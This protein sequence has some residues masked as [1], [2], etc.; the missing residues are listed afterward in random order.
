MSTYKLIIKRILSFNNNIFQPNYI[1]DNIN[2]FCKLYF[3]SLLKNEINV[4]TKYK[5]F[6]NTINN[7]ISSKNDVVKNEFIELFCN[8]QKTYNS[9]NR[10]SCIIKYNRAKLIVDED[11][12]LNKLEQNTKNVICI[13]QN[14][15]KYLFKVHDLIQIIETSLTNSHFF[16]AE[17][18]YIKNPYTNLPFNKSTLYNIYFFIK[19]ETTCFC[20]LFFKFYNCNFNM[21]LFKMNNEYLLREHSIKNY[22]YKSTNVRLIEEIKRLI[23]FYNDNNRNNKILIDTDFPI[24]KLIKIFQPYLLIHFKS[25]FGYLEIDRIDASNEL[26]WR[27]KKFNRFNPLFGRKL[28]KFI[29]INKPRFK[30]KLIMDSFEFN[31]KCTPFNDIKLE[32]TKFLI[33]HLN[34]RDDNYATIYPEQNNLTNNIVS[35]HEED[36][37]EE[38]EEGEEQWEEY[39]D[40]ELDDDSVS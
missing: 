39:Y 29:T 5:F 13:C 23:D 2:N 24:N 36:N 12:G 30:Q 3:F 20:D 25:L 31:D 8:I 22:V 28:Y 7:F 17:P 11:I 4:Q 38:E 33:D 9:L 35:D 6:Y 26:I 14:N 19:L 40:Y 1:S 16:F 10:F 18:Q 37:E 27:L 34:Y 32:N 21:G 15:A